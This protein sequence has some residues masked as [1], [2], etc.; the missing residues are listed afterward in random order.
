MK[1]NLTPGPW[2]VV[3]GYYPGFQKIVNNEGKDVEYTVVSAPDI[4]PAEYH[5]R[6]ANAKAIAAMPEMIEALIKAY[7]RWWEDNDDWA[8]GENVT[9]PERA[10]EQ[11]ANDQNV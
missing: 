11:A 2:R 10:R 5:E 1:P 6:I 3:N 8:Y 9:D 4:N 7:G